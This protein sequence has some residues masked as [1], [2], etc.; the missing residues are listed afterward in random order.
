MSQAGLVQLSSQLAGHTLT[1]I[2]KRFQSLLRQIERARSTLATWQESVSSYRHM[3]AQE[4]EPLRVELLA[5]LRRWVF[6]LDAALDRDAW[7]NAERST[8]RA[9]L[10][11][12]ATDL[13]GSSGED[14]PIKALFDKHAQV[15][16]ETQQRRT[17]QAMKQAAQEMTGLDLGEDEGID[18]SED[19]MA[20]MRQALHEQAQAQAAQRS[21]KAARRGKTAAQQRREHEA[22]QVTQSVREIFRKLASALHPDRESDEQ[23]RQV[24]TELMQRVNQAYAAKDLLTLLELQLQIE[25]ID[26]SHVTQASE[27]RLKAYNKVLSEQLDE[28]KAQIGQLEMQFCGEFTVSP[29]AKVTT[30]DLARAIA[31]TARQWRNELAEQKR[32]LRMLDDDATAKRWLKR[33]RQGQRD[34]MA[35]GEDAFWP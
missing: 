33:Q 17:A 12:A 5:G 4:L 27:Q 13:L 9:L 19:L 25:Q 10:C 26:A 21:A 11:D 31:R 3:Q 34:V 20:R 15:D 1:P 2:Q 7:T 32:E 14:E 16:Y 18:S 24:K 8:L 23:Q 29:G 28:L 30:S 22:Q 6:A 35:F